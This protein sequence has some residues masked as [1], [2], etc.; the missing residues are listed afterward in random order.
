MRKRALDTVF[1]LAKQDP[2]IIFIGS[3]LGVGTLDSMKRDLPNQFFMEGI[4]EQHLIGFA[5]GLAKE[6]FIPYL[7]T[8]ANFFT[9]RALEQLILDVALHQLPVKILASGGGMVYA[10]LGPTHTATDDLAHLLS[11]PNFNVYAPCDA[12][13]MEDLIT[14][15]AQSG[16]PSYFRFGKGGEEIVSSELQL[17]KKGDFKFIG[18]NEAPIALVTTGITLQIC[19]SV[20][21]SFPLQ[22]N[23]QIIHLPK[24]NVRKSQEL[25]E[26][27]RNKARVVVIE[28]HQEYG[29]L[30]TQI[31]HLLHFGKYYNC[32][33]ESISL[34]NNFIRKYGSQVDHLNF[35]NIT[36]EKIT[37]RLVI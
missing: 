1:K 11:I 32:E 22:T 7:N 26:T 24:L 13:E 21:E 36:K 14:L 19:K 31:L 16:Q 27:L 37:E 15:D 9:R 34:G 23:L 18:S 3:D 17:S 29:G 30:L 12:D 6:G 33:T 2:R 28:E 20:Y 8:I 5:A 10:P 25:L 4:S 35:F